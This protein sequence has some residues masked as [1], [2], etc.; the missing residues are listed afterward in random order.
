MGETHQVPER[1]VGGLHPPYDRQ[2]GRGT[3]AHKPRLLKV[4]NGLG[5]PPLIGI[6]SRPGM[7][8]HNRVGK[9]A[10]RAAARP[11]SWRA[12][13]CMSG[14]ES[15]SWWRW[16]SAWPAAG[17]PTRARSPSCRDA[18]PPPCRSTS[19]NSSPSTTGT[20]R[21]SRASRPSRRS[22]CRWDE[23]DGSVTRAS[24]AA[25]RSSGP[26]TSSSSSRPRARPRPTSARTRRSSGSGWPIPTRTSSGSTGAIIEILS[27]A[28]SP[29][30]TSRTGSSRRWA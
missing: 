2:C 11:L 24:M 25:W 27:R 18:A 20:P 30:P 28:T 15:G 21:R 4:A 12:A 3:E 13:Q 9:R 8:D 7:F 26:R 5:C 23:R 29:S 1:D 10:S 6:I 14:D 16:A 17:P 19:T 22:R